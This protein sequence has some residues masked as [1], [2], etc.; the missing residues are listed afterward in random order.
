MA[1][2][3]DIR[4]VAELSDRV[5]PILRQISASMRRVAGDRAFDGLA[6]QASRTSGAFVGVRSAIGRV[7]VSLGAL[8]VSYA[9]VQ[10]AAVGFAGMTVGKF[11]ALGGGLADASAKIGMSAEKL[12]ELRYAAKKVGVDSA[13]IDTG[14]VKLNKVL[15][16]TRAGKNKKAAEY[17]KAMGINIKGMKLEDVLPKISEAFMKN[18]NSAQRTAA[19]MLLFGKAGAD[20]I[21]LLIGGKDGL[22]KMAQK[23]RDLGIVLS[24]A[25]VAAADE[26]GDDLEDLGDA[27]GG[28]AVQ[29]GAKLAPIIGPIVKDMI[30]WMKVNKEWLA[31]SIAD[32]V[33]DLTSYVRDL[34][35]KEIGRQM[36]EFAA[37]ADAFAQKVGGWGNV[38]IGLGAILTAALLAPLL[39]FSLG[40]I[41]LAVDFGKFAASA[42]GLPVILGLGLLAGA[43]YNWNEF[44]AAIGRVGDGFRQLM[45]GNIIAGVTNMLGGVLDAGGA[46]VK[47]VVKMIGDAIGVDLNK[48]LEEATQPL[49]DLLN[50]YLVGP[51]MDAINKVKALWNSMTFSAPSIAP[52]GAPRGSPLNN[53]NTVPGGQP[54]T[55]GPGRSNPGYQQQGSLLEK[56]AQAGVIQSG[57]QRSAATLDVRFS[58]APPGTKAQADSSGPLFSGVNMKMGYAMEGTG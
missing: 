11:A 30:E 52:A 24:D 21:P 4:G 48:M 54:S 7:A 45:D 50:K 49:V 55:Y 27:V 53:Q 19:S 31:T 47:G 2:P 22:A 46:A 23:A 3:L 58:N 44:S 9:S 25:D 57:G 28:V 51:F 5:T 39:N 37:S 14:F 32:A 42:A 33:R 34:D 43:I 26:L 35:F 8:G 6:A 40:L 56:A 18:G 38:L 16:E 12:Q 17:F 13:S 10:G 41:R 20:L 29:I 1:G 15:A 36:R